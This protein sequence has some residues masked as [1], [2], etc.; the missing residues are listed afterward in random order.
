MLKICLFSFQAQFSKLNDEVV[1]SGVQCGSAIGLNAC[2]G[3]ITGLLYQL[4][5][6]KLL[7]LKALPEDVAKTSLPQTWHVPR[8]NKISGAAVHDLEVCGYSKVEDSNTEQPRATRSTLYNPVRGEP[9]NWMDHYMK[10][11]QTAPDFLVLPAIK[12][13]SDVTMVQSKFGPVPS[14]SVL[15][16]QQKLDDDF[17]MN[18]VDGVCFPDL[19]VHN[20][21]NN[22]YNAVL[23][24]SQQIQM[25]GL[26]ISGNEIKRFEE[27]T[28]IQS[29]SPLWHKVQKHRVTASQ[30]G[31]VYKRRKDDDSLAKQFQSKRHVITAAMRRGIL[32]EPVAAKKY[33]ECLHNQV[34]LYPSG[35]VVSFWSPWLAASTDRKVYNPTKLPPFGLLEVKCPSV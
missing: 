6:F 20:Y 1:V 27:K 26:Q 17:I 34:N 29:Q 5:K 21:M 25:E 18:V 28:R 14:G 13:R 2:C 7:E 10:L 15:S 3:H 11:H 30:I 8:G 19:P 16:Y 4:A 33:A 31:R 32:S 23:H 22:N 35:V 24:Q 12:P 9:I